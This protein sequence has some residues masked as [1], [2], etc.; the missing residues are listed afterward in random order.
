VLPRP[1]K[2]AQDEQPG[3][4]AGARERKMMVDQ[5]GERM[6]EQ[7]EER[8]STQPS[9][10]QDGARGNPAVQEAP[11]TWGRPGLLTFAAVM[12]FALGGFHILLAISE[13]ANSTWVLSR[14]D[15]ELFI[16]I[17]AVW[18]IIDVVIG[19]IALFGGVSISRGGDFGWVVGFVFATFGIIRW[20]FY[21]PVSPVLAVVVIVLNA[22]I[23]YGLGKH[24]DYFDKAR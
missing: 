19:L 8:L 12:M 3:V 18:G 11:T 5:S 16:P 7:P 9:T 15:V 13:F 1:Y 14:L 22:I 2:A 20:L 6:P 10:Q 4:K 24:L 21:I 23:I 17:L